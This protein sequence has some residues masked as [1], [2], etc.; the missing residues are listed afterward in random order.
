MNY[1]LAKFITLFISNERY[2]NFSS[3]IYSYRNGN[4]IEK[5]IINITFTLSNNVPIVSSILFVHNILEL[6]K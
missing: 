6:K 3:G 2:K 5:E 4:E 1:L